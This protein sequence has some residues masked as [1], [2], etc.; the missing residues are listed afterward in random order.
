MLLGA[1]WCVSFGAAP[2]VEGVADRVVV[3]VDPMLG[4]H[5]GEVRAALTREEFAV[6]RSMERRASVATAA[7]A[8]ATAS[9]A[10]WIIEPSA[11]T[12]RT[13][14]LSREV[15]RELQ[16]LVE[17]LGLVRI[18]P[19]NVVVGRSQRFINESLGALGCFP[20]LVR[21]GGIHLMGASVCNRSVIV[22]NLTGYFFLRNAS[23]QLTDDMA[24]RREPPINRLD[25]RI[26]ERN[27]S[28]LAHE[29]AHVAR[30]SAIDGRVPT[31]EPAW[32]RE[33]F[34]EIMSGIATVRAFADRTSYTTFHVVRLRKFTD[35]GSICTES[36]RR[37]RSDS[38]FYAGCEYYIGAL[39]VEYL[40]ARMGG[41][42]R[43]VKLLKRASVIMDFHRAFQ[44]TYG[45]SIDDFERRM[46][47]YLQKIAAIPGP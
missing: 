46:D 29:W 1:V 38:E 13:L 41:L 37:Y 44:S 18:V 10:R 23:D 30:A 3:R 31:D 5:S 47:V 19:I 21:T 11:A 9:A 45:M 34:A 2:V 42:D 27:I 36:L 20:N 8:P 39:A 33:G 43:L 24:T 16:L 35:W 28:G 12:S 40:I 6:V 17:R 22:I 7:T 14:A 26:A 4:R 32:F 15:L 25:Y